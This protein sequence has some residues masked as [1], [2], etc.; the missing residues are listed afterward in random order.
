M[1][2][3]S[4]L[5][6]YWWMSLY[7]N[8]PLVKHSRYACLSFALSFVLIF[9][10]LCT[11]IEKLFWDA[12]PILDFVLHTFSTNFRQHFSNS[13]AHVA[14]FLLQPISLPFPHQTV[15]RALQNGSW[16]HDTYQHCREEG[17]KGIKFKNCLSNDLS[18]RGVFSLT[19]LM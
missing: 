19:C 2:S 10:K 5:T 8:L 17:V 11:I 7:S 4:Y 15:L 18:N 13:I 14:W 1:I 16:Q 3:R 6:K 9:D 12:W